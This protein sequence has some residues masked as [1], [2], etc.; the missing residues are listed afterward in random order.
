MP[1]E[2]KTRQT[3]SKQKLLALAQ[4]QNQTDAFDSKPIMTF[5]KEEQT[6][7]RNKLASEHISYM[8]AIVMNTPQ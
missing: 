5:Q 6:Y 7:Y 8:T 3:P 2:W 4:L 1:R